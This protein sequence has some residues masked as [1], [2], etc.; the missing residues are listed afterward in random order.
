MSLPAAWLKQVARD[1]QLPGV[2]VTRF[3]K[4]E[5]ETFTWGVRDVENGT[6]MTP[7]SVF[8]IASVTKPFTADLV[9]AEAAAGSLDL[10]RPIRDQSPGFDLQD[11]EAGRSLTPRDALCHRSGLPPHTWSWVFGDLDRLDWIRERLPHLAPAG[12]YRDRHRYS[13][14]LYAVLGGLLQVRTG[15]TWET[16][17][18]ARL[19]EALDLE[20]TDHLTA[21]WAESTPDM[22]LP[23][24]LEGQ[25]PVRIA[26][27]VARKHHL[28]A[29]ASELMA[30]M[31]DLARLG[32]RE[33]SRDPEDPRFTPHSL[34]TRKRPH[35]ALGPLN[36]GLGWRLDRVKD[37]ARVWHSGQCSGYATLLMLWP[38]RQ[39]GWAM[40]TNRSGAIRALHAMA[41]G[42]DI[43]S[44]AYP[45]PQ[46]GTTR[47]ADPPVPAPPDSLPAG[48][49]HH[50]G[51]GD[52][53]L[54]RRGDRL[55]SKF[56]NSDPMAVHIRN[57]VP[58]I[59]L[60][61]YG[62][63]FPVDAGTD[64]VEVP[65]QAGVPPVRFVRR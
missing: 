51:Y 52:L 1:W 5:P 11:P 19:I 46:P 15:K 40:A 31:P 59:E 64:G 45:A 10:D 20:H 35:P 58:H 57:D 6:A 14:I 17:V 2:V 39:A 38:E 24:R 44:K 28:I 62:V 8:P 16:L 60:P 36:Y 50:P 7:H 55:Y 42:P 33:L 29:P 49:F 34:I 32:E 41:L 9:L 47:P 21:N 27:F 25:R 23:H 65:F 63:T 37:E 53:F 13:N 4:G 3:G 30:S 12:P 22:A 48:H 26:P 54:L 56:Q 18:D 43:G 61:V